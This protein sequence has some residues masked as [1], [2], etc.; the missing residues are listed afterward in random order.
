MAKIVPFQALIY[1]PQ[2][3]PDLAKAVCPPYDIISPA[4]QDYL[5]KLSPY[6]LIH[7]ELA[8]DLAGEDKYQAAGNL[9]QEWLKKKVLVR[10]QAAAVYLYS[11]NR[12]LHTLI[13]L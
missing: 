11:P 10:D 9:F 1:N 2:K 13:V 6:N 5:H 4:R 8:K 12:K 7:L 3:V